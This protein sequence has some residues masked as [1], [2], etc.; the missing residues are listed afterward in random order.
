MTPLDLL[1]HHALDALAALCRR[2][3]PDP[4]AT[5]ELEGALFAPDQ[6]A[7]IRGDPDV[8]F[9]ATVVGDGGGGFVRLLVVDP[10]HQGKGHGQALL[11]AAE[12]DLASRPTVTV[13]ADAPYFLYPG[14]PT[15]QTAMLCLLERRHYSRVEANFNV[16]VDLSRIPDDPGGAE[17][18][19]AD[20]RDEMGAWMS[21]HWPNWRPEVLRALDKGTLLYAR[22]DEGIVGFCA[23]DV[24]R[25][26]TLGPVAVRPGIIGRGVGVPLLVGALHRMRATGR[27]KIEVLWVGPIV[28]YARVGGVVG[29]VFF[30]YQKRLG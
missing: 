18:A 27:S 1:D 7:L 16:D 24:N 5:D 19:T 25:R 17:V 30:V 9:V 6:P 12:V 4:P 13:G 8:G 20:M 23:Y 22:D 14:V 11:A 21:D 3:L 10:S 26:D 28:P 29:R 2:S 15:T